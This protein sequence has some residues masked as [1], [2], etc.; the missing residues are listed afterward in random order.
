MRHA[1]IVIALIALVPLAADAK[2]K[3]DKGGGKAKVSAKG[4][5]DK[6]AKAHKAGKFDVALTELQAAYEIDPQPKLLFAIAQVQAKLDQ[7]PDAIAN[8]E[9]FLASEKNKQKQTVVKQ[10]IAACNEKV[11]AATV[12]MPSTPP[13]PTPEDALVAP[14]PPPVTTPDPAPLPIASP[15]SAGADSIDNAPMPTVEDSPIP[16]LRPSATVSAKPWYKD[17]LGD[18][19]VL[20]GIAAGAV[21]IVMY[22]GARS[23]LDD[24][25]SAATLDD[26][27]SNVAD[28]KDKR[29][30]SLVL[31]GGSAV[32]IGAGIL[33]YK[34]RDKGEA[35]G[36]AIAPTRGGGFI[37]WT[38]GF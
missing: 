28:A 9:K 18:A 11:A 6:A 35:R 17:V 32:L 4:H 26:Y 7:C 13:E 27:E 30:Y 29:T 34:L 8:Y 36:V 10:A 16:A 15:G 14:A 25:E 12:P 33:R 38:G 5:T 19:L 21:S 1:S 3:K 20:S 23:S 22:T 37:T 2:P 31:A 24:A